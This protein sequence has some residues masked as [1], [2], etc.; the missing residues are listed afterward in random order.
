[1][2]LNGLCKV[3][4]GLCLG[5]GALSRLPMEAAA[6]MWLV[7]CATQRPRYD[8]VRSQNLTARAVRC[9]ILYNTAG[10]GRKGQKR[11]AHLSTAFA[12]TVGP[13]LFSQ[14][15]HPF[16]TLRCTANRTAPIK[17]D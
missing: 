17:K 10:R 6:E 11:L 5:R 12:A 7:G 1:M 2:T 16:G 8:V 4:G 3:R 15:K 14:P 9:G 13:T